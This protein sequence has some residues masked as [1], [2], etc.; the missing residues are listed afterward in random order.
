MLLGGDATGLP[1]ALMAGNYFITEQIEQETRAVQE[2]TVY[3]GLAVDYDADEDGYVAPKAF[4]DNFLVSDTI[5]F[6]PNSPHRMLMVGDKYWPDCLPNLYL[7][8]RPKTCEQAFRLA[9]GRAW[10]TEPEHDEESR[11]VG[12]VNGHDITRTV[13]IYSRSMEGL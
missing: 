7:P 9:L 11:V 13:G 12:E 4:E 5:F 2:V 8:E 10:G 3:E 1:I 6:I